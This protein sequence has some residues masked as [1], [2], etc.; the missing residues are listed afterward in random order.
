MNKQIILIFFVV[1]FA[2][3]LSAQQFDL[4]AE[5][6]PRYENKYGYKTLRN[7]GEKA[8][9]FVSQ[10]TRL[11][12][13]FS[14]T[15][16]KLRI[17]LQN[18][19]VWGDVSTLSADDNATALHEAWAEAVLSEKWALKLGRQ[20]IVYDD[21]RIFGNVGWAQQARSHDAFL[22][23]LTPN[24]NNRFDFGLAYNADNQAGIDALYSNA[25]GYKT[26]QYVWYHGD[27]NK[28]D[29]SFLLLN[30]GIE[31]LENEDT[32]EEN[33]TTD[34]MQTIGPRFTYKSGKFNA[35]AAMYYQMGESLKTDISAFYFGSGLGYNVSD[36][37]YVG[38]GF[39]HLSGKDMGDTDAEINSFAPLFGT[40]HKFNG[41]MDYFYVGNHAGNVGLN[42]FNV[43]IAYKK[44]KFSAKIIPHYFSA[45]SKVINAS[46]EKMD[47]ELGTEV[48]FTA[49]YK[50]SKSISLNMGYSLM[51]ATDTMEVIK[52]GDKDQHN[53]WGWIMFTFKP[54]LFSYTPPEE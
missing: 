20:E 9:N 11:N 39:D 25:A 45:P 41:W 6:R 29:I 16:I 26:F 33:N 13:D 47:P 54:K 19:R 46:G 3:N 27:F 30:T 28:F 35:N 31:Y 37:F 52:G 48:D 23:K 17:S 5:L 36:E 22:I 40:N 10:R 50:I 38:V 12:F 8:G 34:Y 7:E 44:N 53:S 24:E 21:H 51:L 14:Q 42:D 2:T 1:L 43:T 15:K 49:G 4:S 32:P 18:V